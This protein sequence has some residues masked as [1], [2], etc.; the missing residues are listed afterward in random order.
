VPVAHQSKRHGRSDDPGTDYDD[1]FAP[2][3]FSRG[4]P[5]QSLLREGRP[6]LCGTL[7]GSNYRHALS[8]APF[9]ISN[10]AHIRLSK[11]ASLGRQ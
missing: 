5:G 3:M 1:L 6:D 10:D 7:E 2:Q 4:G 8:M 9:L 11:I